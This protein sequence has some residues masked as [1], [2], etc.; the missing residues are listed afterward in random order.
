MIGKD[1]WRKAKNLPLFWDLP[2]RFVSR[3]TVVPASPTEAF[4][5]VTIER[6]T[7]P[8]SVDTP[9]AEEIPFFS[10]AGYLRKPS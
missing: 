5:D 4:P 10:R 3:L 2:F 7:S 6:V 1:A 8:E 9:G